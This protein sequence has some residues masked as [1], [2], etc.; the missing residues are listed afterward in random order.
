MDWRKEYRAIGSPF[1][2]PPGVPVLVGLFSETAMS[3]HDSDARP[4]PTAILVPAS[5][6]VHKAK[7]PAPTRKA[8]SPVRDLPWIWLATAGTLAWIVV[9]LM[10]VWIMNAPAS[11][12]PVRRQVDR[13]I[14]DGAL[15]QPPAAK[16]AV[17]EPAAQREMDDPVI[18]RAPKV[19]KEDD[20]DLNV[21]ADCKQIRTDVRFMKNPLEA[22]KRAREEK[23][24]VFVVHLAGNLEDPDFT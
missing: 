18:E 16:P 19:G 22:N 24:L 8:W 17:P 15:P 11:S 9:T 20:L 6:E 1:S 3:N 7:K 5:N 10:I 13:P 14:A 21:F 23:K 4:V 2:C 12:Q